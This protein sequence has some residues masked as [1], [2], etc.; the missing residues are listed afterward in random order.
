MATY[1]SRLDGTTS[2]PKCISIAV[3]ILGEVLQRRPYIEDG[4]RPHFAIHSDH[5]G[6]ETPANQFRRPGLC[7]AD[8]GA[9]ETYGRSPADCLGFQL[10]SLHTLGR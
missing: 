5:A 3:G 4:V 10:L 8:I 2:S 7:S 1:S 6:R 9:K